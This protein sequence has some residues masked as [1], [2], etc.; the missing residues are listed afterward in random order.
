MTKR[1][2]IKKL[3]QESRILVVLLVRRVDLVKAQINLMT[4]VVIALILVI[5]CNTANI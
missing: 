5:V 4:V 2:V 1:K 3:N